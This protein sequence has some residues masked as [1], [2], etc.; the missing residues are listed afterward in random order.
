MEPTPSL[1]QWL[2]MADEETT[3]WYFTRDEDMGKLVWARAEEVA[4]I[5]FEYPKLIV[6]AWLYDLMQDMDDG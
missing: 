3:R 1:L 5:R 2:T 4:R 6:P